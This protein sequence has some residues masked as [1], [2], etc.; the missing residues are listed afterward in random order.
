MSLL[1]SIRS[2]VGQISQR[3]TSARELIKTAK[4]ERLRL[5]SKRSNAEFVKA[6]PD[7]PWPPLH[8]MADA[9]A[10]TS[11][12]RYYETGLVQARFYKE[13]FERHFDFSQPAPVQ[14]FEWGSGTGRLVR[15]LRKLYD[16]GAVTIRGSDYNPESVEWCKSA[17]PD[18]SFFLNGVAPPLDLEND[19][20][21]ILYCSSVFTHLTDDLCRQWIAELERVVRPGGLIAFT[22]AGWS[23]AHRYQESEHEVY[24]RGISVYHEWDEIGRRDFFSWHPPQYVRSV[25]L[26]RLEELEYIPTTDSGLNQ[27][28]WL[29]RVP[30]V[31]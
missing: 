17:F 8:L 7:E 5:L 30:T 13:M 10:H 25:L 31:S 22:I 28:M 20:I 4:A 27:D 23:Y 21:D 26:S 24:R 1:N 15:Q 6:H 29:A 9:H 14:I 12:R 19:S 3:S 11:Y 18:M 16:P 2:A